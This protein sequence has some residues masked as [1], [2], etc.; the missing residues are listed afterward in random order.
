MDDLQLGKG[1]T[2]TAVCRTSF[3]VGKERLS[4]GSTVS[5]LVIVVVR[6]PYRKCAVFQMP[7][8][9][10]L[11]NLSVVVYLH[12]IEVEVEVEDEDEAKT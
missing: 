12:N 10:T 1:V 8:S 11:L 2:D 5:P 3:L 7:T 6:S 9:F 4:V